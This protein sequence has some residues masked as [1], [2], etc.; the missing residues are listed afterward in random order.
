MM[1]TENQ[2]GWQGT[3]PDGF[4][5]DAGLSADSIDGL[6]AMLVEA[7]EQL[8]VA[9]RAHRAA[10]KQADT[11]AM[12][13][14]RERLRQVC[15]EIAA[16]EESRIEFVEACA[17]GAPETT[18]CALADQLEEPRRGAALDMAVRLRGL[19]EQIQ[20]DHRA[21]R[22]AAMAMLG[23]V[24]GIVHQIQQ[25]LNHAGTYSRGGRVDATR[26][27]VVSGIDISS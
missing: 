5:R 6:L 26:R 27:V 11:G 16:L 10:M 12:G 22:A 24:R 1:H 21:M 14:T 15:V 13:R 9:T 19:L 4:D 23:H 7:H 20:K 8:L 17:P 3:L 18:L 25:S 2:H